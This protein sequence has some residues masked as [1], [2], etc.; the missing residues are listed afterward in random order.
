MHRIFIVGVLC[1]LSTLSI[2]FG[3]ESD[4][5]KNQVEKRLQDFIEA[6]NQYKAESLPTFWTEDAALM[7]P[8][9]NEIYKG[10]GEIT[11]FLQKRNQ[12]V[13]ARQLN[14]TFTPSKVQF[15]APNQAVIEG[16][17]EGRACPVGYRGQQAAGPAGDRQ[18][19]CR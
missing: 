2:L 3:V 5:A 6:I 17:V 15:P 19:R 18:V 13:Q 16:V 10:K 14:F 7:N 9:T 11:N 8:A 12:E 4:D 1:F